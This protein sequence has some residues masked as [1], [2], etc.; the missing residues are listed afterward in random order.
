MILNLISIVWPGNSEKYQKNGGFLQHKILI[1]LRVPGLRNF[2]IF[3]EIR[4]AY[5][6]HMVPAL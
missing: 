5:R 1:I 6:N 4:L 3:F 2:L